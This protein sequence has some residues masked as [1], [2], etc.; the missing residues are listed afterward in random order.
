MQARVNEKAPEEKAK[1]CLGRLEGNVQ[2]KNVVLY[3]GYHMPG[4][5]QAVMTC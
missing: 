5:S 4:I 2:A 1:V 3:T